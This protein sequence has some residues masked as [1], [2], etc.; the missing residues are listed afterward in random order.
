MLVKSF[1]VYEG[2]GSKYG[3]TC[4][5]KAMKNI[6]GNSVYKNVFYGYWGSLMMVDDNYWPALFGLASSTMIDGEWDKIKGN[7]NK[8]SIVKF[9]DFA[10]MEWVIHDKTMYYHLYWVYTAKAY[11]VFAK[12]V[13]P[14]YCAMIRF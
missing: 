5:A 3:V 14:V 8:T 1:E 7:K 6:L 10:E 4:S 11:M 12:N 2:I 13:P 9:A